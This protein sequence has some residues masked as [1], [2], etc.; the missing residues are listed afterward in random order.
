[1]LVSKGRFVPVV[2]FSDASENTILPCNS[3]K[4][5]KYTSCSQIRPYGG[6]FVPDVYKS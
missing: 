3:Y 4:L 1:M 6:N 5:K 2:Q